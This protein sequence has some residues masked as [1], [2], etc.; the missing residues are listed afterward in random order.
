MDDIL[1]TLSRTLHKYIFLS[2]TQCVDME[3]AT[4]IQTSAVQHW[5]GSDMRD[6]CVR[7]WLEVVAADKYPKSEW[8]TLFQDKT[9]QFARRQIIGE[10]VKHRITDYLVD[11]PDLLMTQIWMPAATSSRK[12]YDK[13]RM[14]V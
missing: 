11:C 13:A 10:E 5:C 1:R 3:L 12:A 14:S 4:P 8:L 2:I 9:I 7:K 6:P